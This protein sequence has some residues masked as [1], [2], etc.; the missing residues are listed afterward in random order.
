MTI[1]HTGV[2]LGRG[3]EC[4][5]VVKDPNWSRRHA[6]IHC[7]DGSFVI[8]DLG[9]ANG[10]YV[11]GRRVQGRE[12]EPLFFGATITIGDTLLTFTYGRDTTLPDLT[13]VLV[14]Q[15]YALSG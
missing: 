3:D 10:T 11:N 4:D 7:E 5:I 12:P 13:G 2:T 8:D 6:A 1:P 9:S 15:R 14:A